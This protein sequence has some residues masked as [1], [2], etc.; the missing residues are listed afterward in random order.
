MTEED[1]RVKVREIAGTAVGI[2][3]DHQVHDI[4]HENGLRRTDV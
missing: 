3:T 4:L 1:R 2:S